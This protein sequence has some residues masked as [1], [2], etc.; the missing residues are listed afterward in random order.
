[1][2]SEAIELEERL[3]ESL[4]EMEANTMGKNDPLLIDE[5][6]RVLYHG[7]HTDQRHRL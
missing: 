2:E 4:K 5:V 6:Y 1:M 3:I 7:S